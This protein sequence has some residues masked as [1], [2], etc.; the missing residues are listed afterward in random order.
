HLWS[1]TS[2]RKDPPCPPANQHRPIYWPLIFPKPRTCL[3]QPSIRVCFQVCSHQQIRC[4][5]AIIWVHWSIGLRSKKIL[6]RST[7]SQTCTQSRYPR[8]LRIWFSAP[9]SQQHSISQP[10]STRS[11]L[12]YLCNRIFQNI[13]S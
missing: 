1:T 3:Q 11:V 9:G 6:K 10:A 7:L 12:P 4:T 13:P 2:F 5:W 8:I